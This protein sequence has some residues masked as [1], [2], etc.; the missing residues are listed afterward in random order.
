MVKAARKK[1]AKA[2]PEDGGTS[3]DS[4]STSGHREEKDGEHQGGAV[5]DTRETRLWLG[6]ELERLRNT[7]EMSQRH[8]AGLAGVSQANISRAES[9]QSIRVDA[10]VRI[11]R[12]LGADALEVLRGPALTGVSETLRRIGDAALDRLDRD[13]VLAALSDQLQ[14]A[15]V[16]HRARF[17]VIDG[18]SRQATEVPGGDLL[19]LNIPGPVAEAYDQVRGTL[20]GNDDPGIYYEPICRGHRVLAVAEIH[21][22]HI[23]DDTDSRIHL[24][25]DLFR[26]LG[27]LL[28]L[29]EKAEESAAD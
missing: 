10:L 8:L 3:G 20:S 13:A 21:C 16:F 24:A 4:R 25:G 12:V 1:R 26:E 11:L 28:V 6:E 7:K 23:T 14:R 9:G 22:V 17:W 19:D 29:A 27:L 5:G 2:R 15:G 18:P